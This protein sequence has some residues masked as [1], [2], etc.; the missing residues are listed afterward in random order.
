MPAWKKSKPL[1]R[2]IV[3]SGQWIKYNGWLEIIRMQLIID[4][5][6]YKCQLYLNKEGKR[7]WTKWNVYREKQC[8]Q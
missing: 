8:N 3:K 5:W 6:L 7:V 2:I 4:M 1:K